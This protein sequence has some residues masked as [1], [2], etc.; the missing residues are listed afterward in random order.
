MHKRPLLVRDSMLRRL[1]PIHRVLVLSRR[2]TVQ[3][4]AV[5]FPRLLE[6]SRGRIP[7]VHVPHHLNGLVG[8]PALGADVALVGVGA[9]EGLGFVEL[10]N[11]GGVVFVVEKGVRSVASGRVPDSLRAIHG[12]LVAV[13]TK[14]VVV[15]LG[16]RE[17]ASLEN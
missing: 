7:L 15:G 1:L 16:V 11:V 8:K 3:L 4:D 12:D 10:R 6:L 14:S 5:E 2:G 13:N 9:G 17:Q